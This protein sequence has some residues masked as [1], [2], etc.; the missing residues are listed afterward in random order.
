MSHQLKE[1]SS[2]KMMMVPMPLEQLKEDK[3]LT[4]TSMEKMETILILM[5]F[6]LSQVM[7]E[8]IKKQSLG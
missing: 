8:Q 2:C 3:K 1:K 5:K 6:L 7:M 4:L